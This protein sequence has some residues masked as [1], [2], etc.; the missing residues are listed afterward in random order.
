MGATTK[1]SWCNRT[2]NPWTGCHKVSQGCKNCY[3]FAGKRRY[4]ADPNV[5][6][7][8]K[9]WGDPLKWDREAREARRR[10][11]VFTCSWSDFFIEEADPWRR[12]AWRLMHGTRNLI[13]QVLTKRIDH[14]SRWL[15]DEVYGP[16]EFG[17]WSL[18]ELGGMPPQNIWLGVSVEDQKTAD[19]RIP[20][21]LDTPAAIRFLSVEPMLEAVDL[22]QYLEALD[23]AIIGGESSQGGKK[24]RPFNIDWARRILDQCQRLGIPAFIKQMG[25][26]PFQDNTGGSTYNDHTYMKFKNSHGGDPEEWPEWARVREFPRLEPTHA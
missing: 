14:A 11:L 20:T 2:W 5:V 19:A 22:S 3:M 16:A 17:D 18:T 24:A 26:R 12:E 6:V 7:R 1:I 15:Y 25:S 9:T 21:L 8:T 10:D 4:G 13:Y 23:W